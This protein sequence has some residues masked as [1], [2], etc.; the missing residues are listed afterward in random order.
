[1]LGPRLRTSSGVGDVGKP[2][3]IERLPSAALVFPL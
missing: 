2:D 1:V 3:L